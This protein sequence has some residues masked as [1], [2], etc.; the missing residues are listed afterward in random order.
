[1]IEKMFDGCDILLNT[2]YLKIKKNG[3]LSQIKFII[4]AA[5]MNTM[6]IAL[7]NWNIEV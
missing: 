3:M 4:P 6:I 5:S 2:D 1:M 7:A